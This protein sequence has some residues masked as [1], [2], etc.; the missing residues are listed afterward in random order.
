MNDGVNITAK[1]TGTDEAG[2]RVI[3]L[4]ESFNGKLFAKNAS[5]LFLLI[6]VLFYLLLVNPDYV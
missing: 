3:A 6:I 4:N 2:G 1:T 5:Q